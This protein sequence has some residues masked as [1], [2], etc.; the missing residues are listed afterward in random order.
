MVLPEDQADGRKMS[1][2][3]R[4]GVRRDRRR[5]GPTAARNRQVAVDR[6][7]LGAADIPE[8]ADMLRRT[9]DRENDRAAQLRLLGGPMGS[10]SIKGG[11]WR[12]RGHRPI[13][14]PAITYDGPQ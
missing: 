6:G 13:G 5:A 12:S 4:A 1:P 9:L 7:R 8:S 11:S 14:A 3:V 10:A 2:P